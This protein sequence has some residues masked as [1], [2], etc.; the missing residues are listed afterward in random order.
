MT[1]SVPPQ[2]Q[3]AQLE[4]RSKPGRYRRPLGRLPDDRHLRKPRINRQMSELAVRTLPGRPVHYYAGTNLIS[5]RNANDRKQTQ[6]EPFGCQ[7]Q[8]NCYD[9]GASTLI[10]GKPS[11]NQ[12]FP[13]SNRVA[14]PIAG[15]AS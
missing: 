9:I 4:I 2:R 3:D 13:V 7:Q 15:T 11:V 12:V 10:V 5:S 14:R 8:A 6:S 1:A